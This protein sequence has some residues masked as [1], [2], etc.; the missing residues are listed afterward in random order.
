MYK[1]K[2]QKRVGRKSLE[3]RGEKLAQNFKVQTYFRKFIAKGEKSCRLIKSCTTS[4]FQLKGRETFSFVSRDQQRF[5]NVTEKGFCVPLQIAFN[6]VK[7]IQVQQ[8]IKKGKNKK[9]RA[10]SR[11]QLDE[12]FILFTFLERRLF[13]LFQSLH[14]NGFE[15]NPCGGIFFQH[16]PHVLLAQDKQITV[17]N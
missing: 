2:Q 1:G 10:T 5:K 12:V 3:T 6:Q 15:S 8:A 4:R 7:F 17:A 11:G 9:F 16:I 13:V 14:R